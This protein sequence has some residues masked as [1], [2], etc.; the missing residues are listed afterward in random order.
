MPT[1]DGGDRKLVRH[2]TRGVVHEALA[3]EDG[4]DSS[5]N[6]QPADD[7]RGR[8]RIGRR[9][10]GAQH[11]RNRPAH[12]RHHGVRYPCHGRGGRDHQPQRQEA[13]GSPVRRE[14]A[15]RRERGRREQ[16]RRQEDQQS[17][18]RADRHLREPRDE[19]E[20]E[21]AH[22]EQHGIGHPEPC[23]RDGEPHRHDQKDEHPFDRVHRLFS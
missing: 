15:P 17:E 8:D 5:R 14:V 13:N 11:E 1:R 2:Q 7:R 22:H 20:P 19:S 16:Q 21:P 6:L 10:D 18:L 9:D 12:L 23:R 3:L 4:H